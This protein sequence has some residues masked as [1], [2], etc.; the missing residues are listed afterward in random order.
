[1]NIAIFT[2]AYKPIISG[3]V[4]CI[5]L[6]RSNLIKKGHDVVLF[7]PEFPEYEDSEEHIYRYPSLSLTNKVK[8]PLPI[9]IFPIAE[10]IMTSKK[11][12]II[13][14]H[15][16]FV[17]GAEGAKWAAKLNVPLFFTFHTQ[18]EQY[19]HYIPLPSN[20]VKT[21]SKTVVSSY[22]KK[23]SVIITPGTAIVEQLKGYGIEE[24]VVYMPNSID[25]DSF[26]QPEGKSVR[27]KYSIG[28]DEKLLVYVGRMA[29]EKNIPFMIDAFKTIKSKIPSRLMI[30]G[31]GP[32]LEAFKNYAAEKEL[33]DAIIFPGRVEYNQI[34]AYYG[35]SNLFIMT[36]TTEVKPLA[37]L[38]AMAAGLPIVAV[39]ACGVSD[40]VINGENG[41]LTTE[42][43]NEFS[44][45]V[46]KVLADDAL[47][48]EM[49]R[50]S[51]KI[52][53]GYSADALTD[54]LIGLYESAIDKKHNIAYA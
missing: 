6:M 22:A 19:A 36:S 47:L 20:I 28:S 48:A 10:K 26:S 53:K 50:N 11:I 3:V 25:L 38:E 44:D 34:P 42:D 18:Y 2:N 33:A 4:N 31:E 21:V 16:P 30:I 13:H 15:H 40:T 46:I 5:D 23:C 35:A 1:M 27:E 14:C 43:R 17:L 7:A 54:R 49:G 9:T 24:N 12:D 41:F 52:S 8:F 32:E 39:A 45:T 51:V 37:L 29:Q